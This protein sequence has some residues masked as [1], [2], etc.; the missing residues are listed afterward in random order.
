MFIY[1]CGGNSKQVILELLLY[2]AKIK[3]IGEG[4]KK[5]EMGRTFYL[6]LRERRLGT[7]ISS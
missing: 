5:R 2:C 7:R 4:L 6:L 3:E 1:L